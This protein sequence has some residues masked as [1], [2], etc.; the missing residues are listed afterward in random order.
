MDIDV[1]EELERKA[2][3][4]N[5]GGTYRFVF[6]SKNG[7]TASAIRKM[8]EIKAVYLDLKEIEDLFN[9]AN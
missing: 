3:Y 8:D 9:K 1:I 5:Y 2:K 6:V 4:I 7:F